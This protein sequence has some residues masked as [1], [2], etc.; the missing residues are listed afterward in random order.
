MFGINVQ[1]VMIVRK[2]V[3]R[4]KQTAR[5]PRSLSGPTSASERGLHVLSYKNSL[6]INSVN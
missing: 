6:T 5:I 3:S 1:N 2:Q 4:P